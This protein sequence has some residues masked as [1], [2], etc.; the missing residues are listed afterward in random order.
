MIGAYQNAALHSR[1][2][3]PINLTQDREFALALRFVTRKANTEQPKF[4]KPANFKQICKACSCIAATGQTGKLAA[5]LLAISWITASRVGDALLLMYENIQTVN[6]TGLKLK[7]CDGKAVKLRGSPFHIVTKM[8]PL[9]KYITP[10]PSEGL[11]VKPQW[12]TVVT[13]TVK[14]ALK[15]ADK[16]LELRS[17]RRGALQTMALAGATHAV[18]TVMQRF[19]R[20]SLYSVTMKM[21]FSDR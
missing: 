10:L 17:I 11:L 9:E 8:G 12:R 21:R 16:L 13:E 4:P 6:T 18:S 20:T 19:A 3:V 1:A 7:F 14:A 2:I 5:R 15:S